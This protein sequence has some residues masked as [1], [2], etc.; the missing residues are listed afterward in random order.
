MWSTDS[1]KWYVG[2]YINMC[3]IM[4][5]HVFVLL[6]TIAIVSQIVIVIFKLLFSTLQEMHCK[7]AVVRIL[8]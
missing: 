3:Y 2:G 7:E 8:P 4:I 1:L 6:I 5:I